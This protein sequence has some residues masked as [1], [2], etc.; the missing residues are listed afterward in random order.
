MDQIGTL[1]ANYNTVCAVRCEQRAMG[2]K[3][4][5]G[6]NLFEQGQKGISEKVVSGLGFEN[7][8]GVWKRSRF[9]VLSPTIT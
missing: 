5:K 4:K 9:R 1:R 7:R 3:R 2:A 8:V 6:V